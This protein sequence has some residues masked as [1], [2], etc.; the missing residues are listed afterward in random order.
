[1]VE[2]DYDD[3]EEDPD[4]AVMNELFTVVALREPAYAAFD[5][6]QQQEAAAT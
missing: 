2:F 4:L 5:A 3:M 1:M 6:E